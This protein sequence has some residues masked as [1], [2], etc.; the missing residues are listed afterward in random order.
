MSLDTQLLDRMAAAVAPTVV[1]PGLARTALVGGR[2]RRRRRTG[3]ALALA[4]AAV[5]AGSVLWPGTGPLAREGQVAVGGTDSGRAA[6]SWARSLPQGE[7][8]ALPFFGEGGIWSD[9]QMYDVPDEVNYAYP[10]REVAGGWL[11]MTGHD[12]GQLGLAV[13]APDM[14]LREL[15]A[16]TF[17]GGV[18]DARVEVSRDGRRVAYASWVVELETMAV[19]PVPHQ[20]EPDESEGYGATIRMAGFTDEGLVY[21]G[22]PFDEGRGTYWLLRDDGSTIEA[23]PPSG[24][25]GD[26]VPADFAVDYEYASDAGDTCVTSYALEDGAWSEAGHGCMGRRLGEALTVSPD[27]RWLVTDDI[28]EV[29]DLRDGE[30]RAVDMPASVGQAQMAAQMGGVVWEDADSFLLPVSDR[31]DDTV[32]MGKHYVHTVQV[33]RCTMSTGSC[34]QAGEEQDVRVTTSMW[35]TTEL[36]FARS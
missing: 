12:E 23:Q 31:W 1:P 13:M 20:P 28:P 6:L 26:D 34:E 33:V 30:W 17:G 29:W 7:P 9:G 5:V 24:W 18:H 25:I 8:P 21:E 32:P 10:P 36:R 4:T 3:G 2:R 16:E 27:R 19:T 22:A 11:V 35:G 15:P 14:S